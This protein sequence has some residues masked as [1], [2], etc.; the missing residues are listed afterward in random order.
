MYTPEPRLHV[1]KFR[2][3]TAV[4]WLW[5]DGDGH[6]R[7]LNMGSDEIKPSSLPKLSTGSDSSQS[8]AEVAVND[9]TPEKVHV[10]QP[11]PNS[12]MEIAMDYVNNHLR[13]F[14]T[15]P[16]VMGGLGALLVVRYSGMVRPCTYL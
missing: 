16:W 5:Q 6:T 4:E 12:F 7:C 11:S 13:A 14:R 1:Y 3:V 2:V 9:V 15:I 10:I 8:K